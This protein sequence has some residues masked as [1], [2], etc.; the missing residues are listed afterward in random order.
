[1]ENIF[2]EANV[3]DKI[4][5]GSGPTKFFNTVQKDKQTFTFLIQIV[6]PLV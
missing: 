2:T 6:S 5:A 3:T 4:R 1:V